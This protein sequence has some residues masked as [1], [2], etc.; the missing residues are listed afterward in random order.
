MSIFR[1]ERATRKWPV[2][3]AVS[4]HVTFACTARSRTFYCVFVHRQN[5]KIE[6]RKSFFRASII[7]PIQINKRS[8]GA[9]LR[10]FEKVCDSPK[11]EA[12]YPA[13][14]VALFNFGQLLRKLNSAANLRFCCRPLITRLKALFWVE[15]SNE[16]S[17]HVLSGFCRDAG[18]QKLIDGGFFWITKLNF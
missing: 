6:I 5:W 16:K 13:S 17:T 2:T 3:V 1:G 10:Q 14:W 12:D 9:R 18:S 8:R 4:I 11:V 15:N 7:Y